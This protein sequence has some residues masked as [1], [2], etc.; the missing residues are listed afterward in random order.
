MEPEAILTLHIVPTAFQ[1][2]DVVWL[3]GT[4]WRVLT[5]PGPLS[6]G[7]IPVGLFDSDPFRP[8][9]QYFDPTERY[10]VQRL[11]RAYFDGLALSDAR[12]A[13][14]AWLDAEIAWNGLAEHLRSLK[15]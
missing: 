8:I 5:P 15:R 2:R 13:E 6:R 11:D 3:F 7:S 14:R 9:I 1:P 4:G 10:K 12:N